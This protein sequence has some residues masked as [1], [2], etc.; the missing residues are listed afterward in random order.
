VSDLDSLSPRA[1]APSSRRSA[2]TFLAERPTVDDPPV[3]VESRQGERGR[4]PALL[5][6]RTRRALE[7]VDPPR[8][9]RA[10]SERVP[11]LVY[12]SC[13]DAVVFTA[14]I[15]ALILT[16]ADEMPQGLDHFITVRIT[17]ANFLL[18]IAFWMTTRAG[19][20]VSGLYKQLRRRSFAD[21]LRTVTLACAV[22][23]GTALLF[24]LMDPYGAFGYRAVA[25]FWLLCTCGMT[26]SRAGLREIAALG[27]TRVR[28]ILVVG[29]GPR[30]AA[31][32]RRLIAEQAQ[33]HFIVG[34]VDSRSSRASTDLPGKLLGVLEDLPSILL[35]CPIDEVIVALPVKSRYEEI[36]NV[37]DTCECMG[38]PVTLPADAFQSSRIEFRTRPSEELLAVTLEQRPRR[39]A[40]I[41][42]RSVDIVGASIGLVLFS[43]VMLLAAAAVMLTSQGPV[44]FPQDR[45]GHNRRRFRMYKFRTMV[46]G[47]DALLSEMEHLNEAQGPLFKI[48]H[49]PRLTPVGGFLR[50]TS[51]DE[52][53]QLYNV[54]RGEMSLVGPRPLSLRDVHRLP[55][56]TVARRFSVP[57]GVT[58]LWQVN[59][60][61][62]LDFEDWVKY[63]LNYVDQ[64][65]LSLDFDILLRTIPAVIRGDGAE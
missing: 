58:G 29:T 42:K 24:P 55:E 26:L 30:A 62:L 60:R 52:L 10:S 47:A 21:E 8:V 25:A 13:D 15:A 54:L 4:Y 5:P 34:F 51:I 28:N 45:Y 36:Q 38:I 1:P 6:L 33:P 49:D 40:A 61:S 53:P 17:L 35:D 9:A 7:Q 3:N 16:N 22:P 43:P 57:Q 12:R 37:I 18:A 63:D 39:L 46:V 2:Y 20:A 41:V 56:A 59:G 27:R 64:W 48:R 32:C 50:R 11:D 14:V 31:I 44:I 23:A 19:F 65:S